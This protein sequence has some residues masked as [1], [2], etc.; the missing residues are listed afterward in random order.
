MRYIGSTVNYPQRKKHHKTA[1]SCGKHRNS[2]LQNA[3]IKY[4]Q[5][6]FVFEIIEKVSSAEE[7]IDRE[8]FWIDQYDFDADLYNLSPTAKSNL[9][10]KHS[11]SSKQK[12]SWS[13]Q[14]VNNPLYGKHLSVETR[15]KISIANTGENNPMY[16]HI[17]S[18]EFK[19]YLSLLMRGENNPNYGGAPYKR[20]SVAQIDRRSGEIMNT[21]ESIADAAK[22]TGADATNISKICNNHPR[23]KTSGGFK[24]RFCSV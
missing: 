22:Q 12:M 2:H 14:G 5:D 9:G 15:E 18:E 24:W 23:F 11:E 1:L 21:F 19:N 4:G 20:K 17:H 8:Q 10:F 13:K 16:G 7:L 3:Y 6:S